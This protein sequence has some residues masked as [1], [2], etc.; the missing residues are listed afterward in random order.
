MPVRLRGQEG[1]ALIT[2]MMIMLIILP[3]G[4]ALLSIVD[5]QAQESGTERTRDRAFNLAD[6]ALHS[7]AFSLSRYAWP[8]SPETAPTNDGVVQTSAVA[9][10]SAS[11]GASLGAATSAGSLTSRLQPTLNATYDDA[12]YTG[13]AWQVNVC[14]DSPLAAGPRVWRETLL[15]NPSHDANANGLMWVRAVGNVSGRQRVLASLV[16][17]KKIPALQSKY[18]LVTGR[19]NAELTNTAGALLTSGLLGS[20]TSTLLGTDPLVAAD[21]AYV[22]TPPTSGITAV[23]C[24]ALDGCLTGAL[25]AAGSLTLVNTLITG[26]KLVQATSPTATSDAAIAQLK[27]Q[28]VNSG[29]YVSSTPGTAS[30]TS[31]PACT[32]PGGANADTVVYIEQ[33]GTTGSASSTGGA[34]D[35]YCVLDVSVTKA[36]KALVIGSGRVVLRGNNTITA[37]SATTSVN[38]FRGLVYALNQQRVALGDAATPTREVVRIDKGAH[39]FG[40][41]AADGKSAQVG[42]YPPGLCSVTT[43]DLGLLGTVTVDGCVLGLLSTI[44]NVLG[45]YNPA[46]QSNVAL[47]DAV[48]VNDTAA[49]IP[50]T[51][52]DVLGGGN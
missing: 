43:V 27:Q 36:F 48:T 7:T 10:S 41:V 38:T 34:G 24:G 6:S 21:P 1:A 29:T 13:A 14:D 35:Q 31:P 42:V 39:V 16:E 18:G 52:R 12:A 25:A 9:C 30:P 3:L 4:F 23:R 19:M 49:V 50:G 8:A 22:T 17:I 33:V 26:G 20:L 15:S 45:D 37:T 40:G 47:M 32:I 51:Y 44:T 46:I 11:I 2:A 28:A 5:T